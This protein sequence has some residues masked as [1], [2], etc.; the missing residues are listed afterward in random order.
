LE[1][2]QLKEDGESLQVTADKRMRNS[3]KR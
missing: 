2:C 1:Q 3:S